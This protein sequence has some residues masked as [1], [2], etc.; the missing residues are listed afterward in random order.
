MTQNE[1]IELVLDGNQ[2]AFRS[3]VDQYKAKIFR[4]CIGFVHNKEDAE[5]LTQDVF[6]RVFKNLDRF[7]GSSSFSTWIYRIAVNCSLNHLRKQKRSKLLLRLEHVFGI[8]MSDEKNAAVKYAESPEKMMIDEERNWYLH[9][10]IDSLP[11]NQRIAFT[12]S[13][14]DDMSQRDI[15]IVMHITEG[16]VE[17]LLQRAKKNLQKKLKGLIET[18]K[19]TVGNSNQ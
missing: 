17:A 2:E 3:I 13:K 14:Y 4:T 19:L 18:K 15:A 9:K 8:G 11:E 6:V 12:L 10:A 7:K 16:A 5:E 1:L